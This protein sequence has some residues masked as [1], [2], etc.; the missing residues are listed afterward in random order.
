MIV[1]ALAI[2]AA[3]GTSAADSPK[4][5][6]VKDIESDG[7]GY[8]AVLTSGG[9]DCWAAVGATPASV[10]GVGGTGV[11]SGVKRLAAYLGTYCALL[12]SGAVDCWG[13]GT[14]GQLGNGA[15]SDTDTPVR[16]KAVHGTGTLGGVK[17]LTPLAFGFCAVL[18]TARVD[19]WGSGTAGQLGDG[20]NSDSDRPVRVAGVG[21][22]RVL[23]GVSK[24]STAGSPS[25]TC[26]IL[27]NA[28]V[29]CWGLGNQGELGNGQSSNSDVPVQVLGVGG[30]GLL[31]G[32]ASVTSGQESDCAILTTRA[33]YC[34]GLG[35]YGQLGNGSA[36]TSTTPVQVVG[37]AGT[38]TLVN[39]SSLISDEDTYCAVLGS[40][41]ADC[42]GEGYGGEL[43]DGAF[44]TTGILG[45][46]TPVQVAEVG[47]GN[48]LS[49]VASLVSD[50]YSF[51][52]GFCG[53]LITSE[54]DCWGVGF[55][56]DLANGI[57]YTPSTVGSASPVT[58]LGVGGIGVLS[59][60]VSVSSDGS[61]YCALLSTLGVDCWGDRSSAVPVV[62]IAGM[63]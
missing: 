21:E 39:V 60:V 11:I 28:H 6:V 24:L 45:S 10:V 29:D 59:S 36:N 47:G 3:P 2:L 15:S 30:V 46:G 49:A 31:S 12:M 41:E 5:V 40:G 57:F 16:V 62:E 32:V 56:G 38:G 13:L 22:T 23:K 14:E 43:G 9:V 53:V 63:G 27:E 18:D 17:S 48:T 54:V 26:A 33:V 42:W 25:G 4:A 1:G 44:Y 35:S 51:D 61:G 20:A 37:P 8:C 34:W 7:Q 52:T 19:C 55:D 58:A 50:G